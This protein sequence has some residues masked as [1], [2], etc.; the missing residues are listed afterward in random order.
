[1]I[2]ARIE[3]RTITQSVMAVLNHLSINITT[4][5]NLQVII[6]TSVHHC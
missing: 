2:A 5:H 6:A 4:V 3:N 1:M